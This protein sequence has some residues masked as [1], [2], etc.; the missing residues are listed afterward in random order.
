MV[1]SIIGGKWASQAVYSGHYGKKRRRQLHQAGS[2]LAAL[3][4][5]IMGGR[6]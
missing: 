6:Q 4:A 5:R 1:I 3:S 2:L